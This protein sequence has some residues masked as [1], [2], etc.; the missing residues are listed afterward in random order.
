MKNDAIINDYGEMLYQSGVL[1]IISVYWS[2]AGI[3][4]R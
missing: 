2:A 3:F 1:L 4:E